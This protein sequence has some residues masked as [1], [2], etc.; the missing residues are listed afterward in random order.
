MVA[1]VT[2]RSQS[3]VYAVIIAYA[4]ILL[5][6]WKVDLGLTTP[7]SWKSLGLSIPVA[8]S[9]PPAP[10]DNPTS[11]LLNRLLLAGPNADATETRRVATVALMLYASGDGVKR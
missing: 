1:P 8:V 4:L 5:A 2:G 6:L 11:L 10:L 3:S 9:L 7:S